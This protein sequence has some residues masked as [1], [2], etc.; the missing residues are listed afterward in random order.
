MRPIS[1]RENSFFGAPKPPAPDAPVRWGAVLNYI[2][3]VFF[4]AFFA[5]FMA[6]A[7]DPIRGFLP[8]VV[9]SPPAH[10]QPRGFEAALGVS[11]LYART[12]SHDRKPLV[13]NS[14]DYYA[15][16]PAVGIA[17]WYGY[18]HIGRKTA[19][20]GWFDPE[21]M[22]AAHRTLPFGTV[23]R[24]T[25]LKNGS[26]VE[27]T[28]NDRGPYVTGRVIDL[29]RRPATVIGLHERG[30]A[31]CRVEV[32]K[33]PA[34]ERPERRPGPPPLKR[35]APEL[36]KLVLMP[37]YE[38]LPELGYPLADLVPELDA[39]SEWADG[40]EAEL[41]GLLSPVPLVQPAPVGWDGEAARIIDLAIPLPA[42][43]PPADT[44]MEPLV[45][46]L[47]EPQAGVGEQ[48]EATVSQPV[49]DDAAE[50]PAEGASTGLAA[51][52]EAPH[53]SADRAAKLGPEAAASEAVAEAPPQPE[54][55]A[56]VEAPAS[57]AVEEK[58][59]ELG[60]LLGLVPSLAPPTDAVEPALEIPEALDAAPS[61]PS[62]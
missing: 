10:S 47:G 5:L 53:K 7:T 20:G 60:A 33:Y 11:R 2:L 37:G 39:A 25:R 50:P 18:D 3:L 58:A 8:F 24:V 6:E 41:S 17:S 31:R 44:A 51:A 61:A 14:G 42:D 57:V 29:A 48:V 36:K 55:E 26:S 54:A 27:V 1:R 19:D 34:G 21:A 62:V 45:P 16:P 40:G 23:V 4:S 15:F 35:A 52:A 32:L 38:P 59:P 22:T 56:V 43:A 30:V 13:P 12:V 46:V 28:I 49:A 9:E